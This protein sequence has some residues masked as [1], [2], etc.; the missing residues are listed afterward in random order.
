MTAPEPLHLLNLRTVLVA[1]LKSLCADLEGREGQEGQARRAGMRNIARVEQL[2]AWL[3]VLEEEA[4]D[5]SASA[6]TGSSG[7]AGGM[8][9]DASCSSIW[10]LAPQRGVAAEPA[11]ASLGRSGYVGGYGQFQPKGDR[12]DVRLRASKPAPSPNAVGVFLY[13]QKR[14]AGKTAGNF[15]ATRLRSAAD[16]VWAEPDGVTVGLTT[17]GKNARFAAEV[18]R[19]GLVAS[20]A[21][22]TAAA[23]G[24]IFYQPDPSR[25]T[26][27]GGIAGGVEAVGRG[28]AEGLS[29]ALQKV[30]GFSEE[31]GEF[32]GS[33]IAATFLAPFHLGQI[34][35]GLRFAD[36]VFSQDPSSGSYDK[37]FQFGV[38]SFVA[39]ELGDITFDQLSGKPDIGDDGPGVGV[40]FW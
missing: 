31:T 13:P 39:P 21:S 17:S 22:A 6:A 36:V 11:S 35:L 16:A 30:F 33:L 27:L 3:N 18:L 19:E 12:D 4:A 38:K 7:F 2:L 5:A 34:S 28:W 37:L 10:L 32:F 40:S 1:R 24:E 9:C 25:L 29:W 8:F 15:G 26:T 14:Q 23:A 20:W